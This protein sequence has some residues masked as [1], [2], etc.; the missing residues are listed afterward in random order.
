MKNIFED[1]R[2][3]F[4]KAVND[5]CSFNQCEPIIEDLIKLELL[6]EGEKNDRMT[7]TCEL[8]NLLGPQKF[9]E[10]VE[11]MNGRLV[12]FPSSE[13]FKETIMISIYYYYRFFKGKDWKEID[14]IFENEEMSHVKLG[15][16]V[17]ALHAFIQKQTQLLESRRGSK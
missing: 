16:R 4:Q 11:L 14:Q 1:E 5:T 10:V 8:Y 13:S 7:P 15:I 2:S 12:Q 3:L 9:A 6:K 17:N